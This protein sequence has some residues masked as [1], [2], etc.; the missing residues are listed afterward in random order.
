M[1]LNTRQKIRHTVAEIHALRTMRNDALTA[2]KYEFWQMIRGEVVDQSLMLAKLRM[3]Y[4]GEI[5]GSGLNW[6]AV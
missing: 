4:A 2:G 3:Q 1:K 5:K 6:L